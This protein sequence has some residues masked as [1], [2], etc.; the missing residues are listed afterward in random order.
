MIGEVIHQVQ[1]NS[2]NIHELI[3]FCESG[4][5]YDSL[6]PIV[7]TGIEFPVYVRRG[8]SD[9]RNFLQIFGR[10]EYGAL[11]KSP[12]TV[13]DLGAYVGYAA[14]FLLKKYQSKRVISLEPDPDTFRLLELNT[15]PYKNITCINAGIWNKE[16][17]IHIT[18]KIG[19]DWGTIVDE[20]YDATNSRIECQIDAFSIDN[21][22]EKYDLKTIDF[23]KIDIEG[24]ERKIFEKGSYETW[25]DKV[26]MVS[27]EI[28]DNFVEGCTEAYLNA[29]K[30]R[31]YYSMTSGEFKLFIRNNY[32]KAK[33]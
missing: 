11:P 26:N 22:I 10:L 7:P 21:I 20:I 12:E 23:L 2:E 18:N 32:I 14:V 33:Q 8:T 5:R 29:F 28:H 19:G 31:D 13:L 15:R 17:K 1:I 25:I 30:N 24:S 4:N 3:R 16:C 6:I 9:F 27:C